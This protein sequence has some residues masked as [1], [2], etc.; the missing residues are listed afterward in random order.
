MAK[1]TKKETLDPNNNSKT[2]VFKS[3]EISKQHKTILGCLLILFSIALLVAF[4]S[5]YIYGQEDQSAVL[6]V[7]NRTETVKNWLGKFGAFLANLIV[8][9]GFGLASFLFVRLLFLSGIFLILG[10]SSRKLK[11]IWFWDLFVMINLSVIWFFCHIITGIR[12]NNWL[13]TQFIFTGLYR[14][15][16]YF[17]ITYFCNPYLRYFQNKIIS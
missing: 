15:N 10:L 5:F 8:Y 1:T 4:V 9:Q 2:K 12:R 13:R 17:V 3:W 7:T 14:K 16:R 6:E 11:N